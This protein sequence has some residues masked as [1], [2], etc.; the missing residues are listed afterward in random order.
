MHRLLSMPVG[1][2]HA[3]PTLS[4]AAA[5]HRTHRTEKVPHTAHCPPAARRRGPSFQHRT[6]W[7]TFSAVS[8][9]PLLGA[10]FPSFHIPGVLCSPPDQLQSLLLSSVNLSQKARRPTLPA[11]KTQ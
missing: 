6:F 9:P 7:T 3:G 2:R 4:L 11:D 1:L 10:A 8:V 5:H